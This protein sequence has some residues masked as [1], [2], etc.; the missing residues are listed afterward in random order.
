VGHEADLWN[1]RRRHTSLREELTKQL[2]LKDMKKTGKSPQPPGKPK[3]ELLLKYQ[4]QVW[5]LKK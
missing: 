3:T 4:H 2:P 5:M 1:L